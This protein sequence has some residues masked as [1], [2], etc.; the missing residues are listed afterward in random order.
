MHR[1]GIGIIEER[2]AINQQS[3]SNCNIRMGIHQLQQLSSFK[4]SMNRSSRKRKRHSNQNIDILGPNDDGKAARSSN[5]LFR[6]KIIV[7]TTL[8]QQATT[9]NVDNPIPDDNTM[10]DTNNTTNSNDHNITYKS[11]VSLIR[12]KLGATITNQVH[13]GVFCVVASPAAIRNPTQRIRK[14]WQRQVPVV[15]IQ[16]I[17]DCQA[18]QT[19][20]PIDDDYLVQPLQSSLLSSNPIPIT[21][22]TAT[23]KAAKKKKSSLTV[24]DNND[25]D[26][27]HNVPERTVDLGCCCICHDSP[28]DANTTP[29]EWCIDCS[30]NKNNKMPQPE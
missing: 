9:K 11:L 21:S 29:C 19:M 13:R 7:V 2:Q 28:S 16:Y 4:I 18:Q 14:A 20:L 22:S 12:E 23:K 1:T 26:D 25:H 15:T 3:T 27:Y 30:Y 24:P 5:E 17:R 8:Q 6:D 10:V